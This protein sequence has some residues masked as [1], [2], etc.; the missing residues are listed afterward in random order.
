[1][2]SEYEYHRGFVEQITLSAARFLRHGPRLFREWPVRQVQLQKVGERLARV[3]SS[4]L[5]ARVEALTLWYADMGKTGGRALGSCPY[6]ANL[7][8]LNLQE[9]HLGDSGLRQLVGDADQIFPRLTHLDLRSAGIGP[10]GARALAGSPL[11]GRLTELSLEGNELGNVGVEALAGS[12]HAGPTLAVLDLSSTS[13]GARG[14][15]ALSESPLLAGLTSLSLRWNETG[16]AAALLFR[17]NRTERLALLEL[18]YNDLP[19]SVL[20]A[21]AGSAHLKNLRHL[22]LHFNEIG[23]EGGQ[24]LA[25]SP[26]LARLEYLDLGFNELLNAGVIPL[27]GAS[28]L[29]RGRPSLTCLILSHNHLGDQAIEALASSPLVE[30]LRTLEVD[31]NN[32]HDQGARALARSPRLARLESLNVSNNDIS[33]EGIKALARSAYLNQ[34]TTLDIETNPHGDEGAQ[35]LAQ[36]RLP[37]LRG[38]TVADDD[39]GPAGL[40]ALQERFGVGLRIL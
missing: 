38:L 16:E 36:T 31:F 4:L 15:Q 20:V 29:S 9:N 24:A 30:N 14:I 26:V 6:L 5:L 40:E 23:P 13:I 32:C 2:V 35:A 25:E 27:A 8:T 3:L 33:P 22:N 1:M 28:C 12:R 21:L 19:S 34:L 10:G 39:M 11:L 18:P 37:R 7:K 17:S